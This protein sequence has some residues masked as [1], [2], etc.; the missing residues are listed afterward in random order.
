MPAA[1]SEKFSAVTDGAMGDNRIMDTETRHQLQ[2]IRDSAT[3]AYAQTAAELLEGALTWP[4][5]EIAQFIDGYVNDP[6][7]TRND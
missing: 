7:L 6:Y 1:R 4:Q 2:Q 3:G 5:E